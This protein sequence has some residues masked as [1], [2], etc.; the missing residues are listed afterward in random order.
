VTDGIGHLAEPDVVGAEIAKGKDL[1]AY[2]AGR[3]A[4]RKAVAGKQ[5]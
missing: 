2:R 3:E 1:A 5:R 4:L